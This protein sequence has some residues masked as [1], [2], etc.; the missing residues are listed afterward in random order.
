VLGL[1]S[2]KYPHSNRSLFNALTAFAVCIGTAQIALPYVPD[3]PLALIGYFSL[4]LVILNK[5]IWRYDE[6]GQ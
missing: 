1:L 5:Y 4:G 3:I 6:K 2:L